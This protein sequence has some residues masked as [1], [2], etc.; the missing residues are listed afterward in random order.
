MN[1]VEAIRR[2]TTLAQFARDPQGE[3]GALLKQLAE[4]MSFDVVTLYRFVPEQG[5]LRP[6]QSNLGVGFVVGTGSFRLG[7]GMIGACAERGE[8]IWAACGAGPE[9]SEGSRWVQEFEGYKTLAAAPVMREGNLTGV[10]LFLHRE[11]RPIGSEEMQALSTIG[12][13][14][15]WVMTA[16]GFQKTSQARERELAALSEISRAVGSTLELGPLTDMILRTAVQVTGARGGVLRVLDEGRDVYRLTSSYGKGPARHEEFS[17]GADSECVVVRT[18][19]PY[20]MRDIRNDLVC[21][22]EMRYGISSCVCVP[23]EHEGRTVGV[24]SVYDKEASADGGE[25]GF[26]EGD[27]ELL[28]TMAGF[29]ASALVRAMHHRRIQELVAEKEAMVHELSILHATSEALMKTV[30]MDLILRVILMGVTMGDGLGFNRAMLFLVNRADGVLEGR[31]GAGPGSADEA[32]RVWS[33]IQNYR[34]TLS[35]WLDWAL[36]QDRWAGEEGLINRVA[37]NIRVPLD[38][39][40]C[41]LIR[42]L[43]EK[44]A[45]AM[46]A[47]HGL[48]GS[49]ML[50]PLEVGGEFAC[51]PILARGEPL[52]VIL[53]DNIYSS[54]P[55][56]QRDLRFLTA[57]AS[58]AGLAIQNAQLYEGLRKAHKELQAVQQ[59]L[60]QSE[61]LAA[62]GEFSASVAHEIRNPLVSIGGYARLLQKKHRDA[63]SQIIYQEVGR[64]ENILNR[65]LAF[66]KAAP[67][68]WKE[69]DLNLVVE[70][71][72]QAAIGG[73]D[74]RRLEIRREWTQSLPPIHCDKGQLKQVFLNLVQNALEAMEGRGILTVRTYLSSEE[75]GLW[76]VAEV[77]D[78][79]KGIPGELIHNVFN[80]FFTTKEKGTGLGLAITRRI[81]EAHGGRIELVNRPGEG[82]TFKVKLPVAA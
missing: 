51:A 66:S 61:R 37:R 45:F 65:V 57:F 31:V 10:V 2:V 38:D 40:R 27:T 47:G 17:S 63:Y 6:E 4:E 29:I 26:G 12:K 78:T 82:S 53:V 13:E 50:G 43:R 24:L 41:V 19:A 59:R 56:G 34:W 1:P 69:E 54:R 62:L 7:E 35:E 25:A 60:I 74:N 49:E 55:I 9:A 21:R 23:L 15:A 39:E 42:C 58:Q 71:S 52:G 72:L 75:D 68:E 18:G 64:L 30:E 11:H 16:A 14:L 79:G 8:A 22:E 81:V 76:A 32:G 20:V 67:A 5:L 28:Q 77:V 46:P 73:T 3:I 36:A 33:E 70:E 48:Y 44:K 80:P